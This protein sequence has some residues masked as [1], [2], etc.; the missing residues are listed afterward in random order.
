MDERADVMAREGDEEASERLL[1]AMDGG[2]EAST[3]ADRRRGRRIAFVAAA[4][5]C[6][7]AAAAYA[8]ANGGWAHRN[9][10]ALREIDDDVMHL[11]YDPR[12]MSIG[13]DEVNAST[14][15][16]KE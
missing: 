2:V 13:Y 7:A 4:C 6:A 16:A 12:A 11:S 10:A 5:C 14:A 15:G 8:S 1:R 9:G 3:S